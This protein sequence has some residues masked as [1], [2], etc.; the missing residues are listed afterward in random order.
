MKTPVF[1][2][3]L[4][5]TLAAAAHAEV[6]LPALISDNM[7]LQQDL[8]AN[9]WGWADA[10]E[11]VSV[12]FGGK[13]AE[14]TADAKGKWSV[15]LA[16]LASGATG[17]MTVAGTNTLT[18][19]NVAVGEVWVCSGQSNME[20]V[21]S[22]GMNAVEEI[23]GADFPMIRHFNVARA[24]KGEPQDN[25][26]GKWD[27]CSPQTVAGFTA[28]G[29]FFGRQLHKNLKVP[30]GLIHSSWGGTAAEL[31][32]PWPV[33]SGDPDFK[34]ITGAWEKTVN[35]YPAAKARYDAEMEV[36]SEAEKKAKVAGTPPPA[37][38]RAPKGGDVVGSPSSL[39]NGMIAPLVPYT[40]RGVT[41][42]QGESNA[43]NATLYRKLF[44]VMIQS[45]RAAWQEPDSAFLF[46]QLANYMQRHDEPTD[47]NW[48][49]LREAQTRALALPH[50]GMALAID[51]GD[52]KDIHPKDKQTVGKRLALAAEA[53]VY[54]RDTEY[55]GPMFGG[56][57]MEGEKVRL[58]FR[59]GEGM[60]AAEGGKVKG[61]A[62]AGEDRKFVWADAE[63]AGDHVIISSPEV[64]APASVRYAWADNPECNLINAAGLPASPFRTDDWPAGPAPVKPA[65]K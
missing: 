18:I 30:V 27:V 54:Y 4:T 57:Q 23:S 19:K 46:V 7:V 15:K 1:S 49:R 33:L 5:A 17:E 43:G 34:S 48:A 61:F 51:V 47:T 35:D 50:T 28:V 55:S 44:P 11:K 21:V 9:V 22:R 31:W 41:W 45:W 25:C 20:F 60:K 16:G 29:Y 38:P 3:L 40:I 63:I 13:S 6:K 24:A 14:A 62:I 26:A 58:T 37:P 42:Y 36:W 59:H 12:K 2:L 64:K 39:Y 10:G 32:T 53:T 52:A 8:P 56:A 65:V